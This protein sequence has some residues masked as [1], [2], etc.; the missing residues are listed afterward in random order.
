M[1]EVFHFARTA[2][3]LTESGLD[4]QLIEISANQLKRE[5]YN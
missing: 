4:H 3:I 2:K 1:K 5:A